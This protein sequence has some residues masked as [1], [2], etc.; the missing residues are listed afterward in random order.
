MVDVEV[1][2]WHTHQAY[3]GEGPRAAEVIYK[4]VRSAKEQD[5][6]KWNL[7]KEEG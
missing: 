1:E 3:M 4:S 6:R 7:K 2:A 5:A